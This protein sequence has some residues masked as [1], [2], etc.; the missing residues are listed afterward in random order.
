[1]SGTNP[2]T[3]DDSFQPF[4]S[5]F[6]LLKMQEPNRG[7]EAVVKLYEEMYGKDETKK[8]TGEET[9]KVKK[10]PIPILRGL[11]DHAEMPL[12]DLLIATFVM[13]FFMPIIVIFTCFLED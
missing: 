4:Q 9:I 10:R 13:L 12:K 7:H 5:E 3:F 11:S 1:M 6:L 2:Y 8:I